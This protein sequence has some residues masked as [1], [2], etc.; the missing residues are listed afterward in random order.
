MS[1][2]ALVHDAHD[3]AGQVVVVGRVRPRHLRGLAA[4]ER[5]AELGAGPGEAGDDGLDADGV[6]LPEGDVVEEE[7][8]RRAL[9]E[10]VV[11]AVGHE[12]VAHGV[13]HAG[14]RSRP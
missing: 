3:E 12:V 10:D 5:A 1:A 11:H 7:E 9:H 6:H 8:R 14:Q 13:V 2:F 4:D